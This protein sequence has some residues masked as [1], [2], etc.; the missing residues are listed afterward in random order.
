MRRRKIKSPPASSK[1]AALEKFSKRPAGSNSSP[2]HGKDRIFSGDTNCS[3]SFALDLAAASG[4]G[5]DIKTIFAFCLKSSGN[6]SSVSKTW[7]TTPI[8]FCATMIGI[9]RNARIKSR[10]LKFSPSGLNRPPAPS[11]SKTSNL[12]CI[13]RAC[14]RT[15]DN[16]MRR[17]SLRAASR[18]AMGARKCHGLISSSV[19]APFMAACSAR[20][21]A[22]VPEQTGLSAAALTPRSRRNFTSAA[23]SARFCRRRCPCR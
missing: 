14:A 19:S 21:S 3:N 4:F 7:F 1:F 2:S 11:T 10:E 20:A 6:A 17:F 9:A 12:F 18:G 15:C 8:L 13:A 23:R 16:F 22:R 5:G